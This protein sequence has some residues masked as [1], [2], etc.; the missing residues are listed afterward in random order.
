MADRLQGKVIIITGG[1]QGIGEATAHLFASEGAAVIIADTDTEKG[2]R[3]AEDIGFDGGEARFFHVDIAKPGEIETMVLK[4]VATYGKLDCAFNSATVSGAYP[5]VETTIEQWDSIM[6]TNLKGVWL[7][8]K[9]EIQAM[10][11]NKHGG[12]IVNLA[13]VGGLMGFAMTGAFAASKGGVIALSRTAAVECAQYNIR[14]NS[15]SPDAVSSD[16]FAMLP[17]ELKVQIARAYPLH[18]ASSPEDIAKAVLY[19]CSDDAVSLTGHNLVIDGGF[20]GH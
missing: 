15:I 4:T 19:L 6:N 18:R 14:V 12:V 5:I 20:S 2:Q 9:Y 1:T 17:D 11:K 7:S 16:I 10:M 8:M 13:S 3:M